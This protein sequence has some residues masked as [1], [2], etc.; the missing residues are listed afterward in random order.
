MPDPGYFAKLRLF[1]NGQRARGRRRQAKSALRRPAPHTSSF[2]LEALEPRVLLSAI[3]GRP[4]RPAVPSARS[5]RRCAR[6]VIAPRPGDPDGAEQWRV[7]IEW[8]PNS[9]VGLS[10]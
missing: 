7:L 5:S 2:S 9:W 4:R 10:V 6:R 1:L 3:C 8:S